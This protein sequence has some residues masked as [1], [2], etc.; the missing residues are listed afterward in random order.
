MS[1]QNICIDPF[2]PPAIRKPGIPTFGFHRIL[3][4]YK[5]WRERKETVSH[6]RRL[7][8]RQLRDIGIVRHDLPPAMQDALF[9]GRER[10]EMLALFPHVALQ[11]QGRRHRKPC[12]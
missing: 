2:V 11:P 4:A 3:L 8:D 9:G 5:A 1:E 7:S 12:D 6:L 10:H